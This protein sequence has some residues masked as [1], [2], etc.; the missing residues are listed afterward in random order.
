M[1]GLI[2]K[3]K[4]FVA[5]KIAEMP[6]PEASIR[7]VDLK[8]LTKAGVTYQANLGVMNPYSHSIPICEISYSLKSD[9][10]EI[11]SG[12]IPDPGSIKGKETTVLEVPMLVPHDILLSIAKDIWRDWDID[13]ELKI[14]LIVDLPI[15]GNLTIPLS[16]KGEIKL[17]T[18][19]DLFGGGGS[20]VENKE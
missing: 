11:A 4:N 6:K 7:D 10:R 20:N 18:L 2:D 19:G 8:G 3:A 17:P 9:Q 16:T 5:D 12:K 1:S 14:G 13:Y 15:I